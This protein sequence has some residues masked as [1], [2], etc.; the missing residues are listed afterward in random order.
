MRARRPWSLVLRRSLVPGESLVLG[1]VAVFLFTSTAA[2]QSSPVIPGRISFAAAARWTGHANVGESQATETAA[3]GGRFQLF[4]T[5]T[6]L[7]PAIGVEARVGVRL[8]RLIEVETSASFAKPGLE[9]RVSG[10]AE[11]ASS[12]TVNDP[13]KELSIG[14]TLLA[15]VTRMRLGS[16]TT[17]FVAAGGSFIRDLHDGGTLAENG[18]MY[19]VGGGIQVVIKSAAAGIKAVGIRVDGRAEF[20]SG[21]VT[22]DNNTHV[23]P[24]VS[25]S[26]FV[27]F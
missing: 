5:A 13:V 11:G 14:G 6:T 10:D 9:T 20:R 3:S 24:S 18:H 1:A 19:H 12:L 25:A 15:H 4:N 21:G 22:F 26:L 17:P 8:T 7:A 2:A 23:A 16:R 27:R